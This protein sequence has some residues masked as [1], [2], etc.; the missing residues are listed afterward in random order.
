MRWERLDSIGR[1]GEVH[2]ED[3]DCGG[4]ALDVSVRKN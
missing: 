2:R 4:R 3:L 1:R